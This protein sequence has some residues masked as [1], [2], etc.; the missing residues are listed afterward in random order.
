MIFRE[1]TRDRIIPITM[2]AKRVAKRTSD[3]FIG[4]VDQRIKFKT[5]SLLFWMANTIMTESSNKAN[6]ILRVGTYSFIGFIVVVLRKMFYGLTGKNLV[7]L[8]S[9]C[10]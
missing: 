8:I 3:V 4:G 9:D 7:H 6:M 2:P 1:P 10:N 5:I